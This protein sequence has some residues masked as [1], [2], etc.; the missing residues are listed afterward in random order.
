MIVPDSVKY[1]LGAAAE[2]NLPFAI[3]RRPGQTGIQAVVAC[4]S[5]ETR[6]VFSASSEKTFFAL[7][8]FDAMSPNSVDAIVADLL[9]VDSDVQY[10]DGNKYTATPSSSVQKKLQ[11]R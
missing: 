9:V 1:C 8:R 7:N 11:M 4:Q 5:I 2:F 3:W 6:Q 10:F